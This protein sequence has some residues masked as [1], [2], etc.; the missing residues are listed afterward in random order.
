MSEVT[1]IVLGGEEFLVSP[2]PFGKV[3]KL[4]AAFNGM[5][6][7]LPGSEESMAAAADVFSILT[8]RS[9]EQID[10]MPITVAEMGAVLSIVPTLCGVPVEPKKE[11]ASGEA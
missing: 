3:R 1:K 7:M 2:P 10:T 9:R 6:Y 11:G 5:A 4:M 8:D